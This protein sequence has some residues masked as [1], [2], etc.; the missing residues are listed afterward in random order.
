MASSAGTRSLVQYV[1][2]ALAGFAMGVANVIP[3]VSGGTMAFILGIF[4]ELI[5]SIREIASVRTLSLLLRGRFRELY[6][7]LP[8]RFL[9]AVGI[10]IVAALVS[11]AKLFTWALEVYPSFT[12][13]LFL[14]LMIPSVW[15]MARKVGRWSIGAWVA[16]AAGTLV[17]FWIINLVPDSTPNVWWI[18]LLSGMVVICAMILP[19]ISGSFLLLILG[20]YNYLWGAVANLPKSLFTEQF[21]TMFWAGIGCVIGLGAFVHLLNWLLKHWRDATMASLIGF[22]LGSLPVLWPWKTVH[23]V[24]VR[25]SGEP[26]RT[27]ELPAQ[28]AALEQL[29]AQGAKVTTLDWSYA[30]PNDF[31]G[32]FW[33]TIGCIAAGMAIVIVTEVLAARGGGKNIEE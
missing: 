22:M 15:M 30:W 25:L 10:G 13:A 28:Q 7:T 31:G 11:A 32:A 8:W 21:F 29:Q 9:L 18:S 23:E 12:F 26:S 24:A 6:G 17:A 19:G 16:L 27:L 20:Q 5:D 4:E 33:I 2:I 1:R 14:G 3:G